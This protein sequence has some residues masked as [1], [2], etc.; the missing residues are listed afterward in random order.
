MSVRGVFVSVMIALI[1]GLVA[2]SLSFTMQERD[3]GIPKG[4]IIEPSFN[5]QSK[6]LEEIIDEAQ[7]DVNS[8]KTNGWTGQGYVS[9]PNK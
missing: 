6:T 8:K 7:R 9:I 1:V 5:T 4:L 2:Y 3:Y